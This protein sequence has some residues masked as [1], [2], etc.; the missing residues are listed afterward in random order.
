L[1]FSIAAIDP[2]EHAAGVAVASK[3]LGAGAYVPFVAADAGAVATQAFAKLGFGPDGLDR[4]RSGQSP[5]EALQAMLEPDSLAAHRQVGLVDLEGR[6]AAHTGSD[7]IAWAGHIVGDGFTVQGNILT[8]P[9]VL[10]AMAAAYRSATGELADRLLAALI[11]GDAAGGDRRGRQSAALSVAKPNGGYGGDTDRYLDLRVDDHPTP[12]TELSRLLDLHRLYFR[13]PTP[14]Q[15]QPVTPD[16]AREIQQLI[17]ASGDYAGE[18]SGNWDSASRQAFW[19]WVS[20]ENLEERWSI[21]GTPQ[22]ID[23]VTL[24]YVR[25]KA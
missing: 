17:K 10:E 23:D 9:D 13:R 22:M 16:I 6:A 12:A 8:G 3:F 24:A 11:A 4:M 2:D 20:R 15:M 19:D 25:S 1:T 14:D 18:V 5:S 21:R 7:C